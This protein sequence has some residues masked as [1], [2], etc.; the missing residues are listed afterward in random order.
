MDL[1]EIGWGHGL[2]SAGTGLE[3]MAVWCE[4]LNKPVGYIKY[5]ELL[6]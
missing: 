6:H 5:G 1:K 4:H 3:T 2:N